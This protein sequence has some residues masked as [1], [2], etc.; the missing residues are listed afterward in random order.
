MACDVA[1]R[2]APDRAAVFDLDGTVADTMPFLTHIAGAP[3][4]PTPRHPCGRG[5]APLPGQRRRGLRHAGRRDGPRTS[6]ECGA[7]RGVRGAQ[8]RRDLR[9]AALRRRLAHVAGA[10]GARRPP[11]HRQQYS[12][13]DRHG[14]RQAVRTGLAGRWPRRLRGRAGQGP[15]AGVDP[16][17]A[18]AQ[19]SRGR[20]HGRLATRLRHRA[21][22]R[23]AVRG[24]RARR[25]RL[26]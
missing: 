10:E 5:Q 14:I 2:T 11:L 9:P 18:R 24:R 17:G 6:G 3:A 25:R 16:R 15:S 21:A 1:A 20:L 8:G 19:W 22:G 4:E 12:T 23:H 7:R 26:G 13:W